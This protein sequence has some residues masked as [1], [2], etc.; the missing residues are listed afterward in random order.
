MHFIRPFG[1]LLLL[2]LTA[3]AGLPAASAL[4]PGELRVPED[5]ETIQEAIDAALADD[6]I[7]VGPGTYEEDL[8]IVKPLTLK[9]S[10]RDQT[11]LVG[12]IFISGASPV[13]ISGFTIRES[14]GTGIG[15]QNRAVATISNCA[16]LRS[17]GEGILVTHRSEAVLSGNV[18]AESSLEGISVILSSTAAISGNTI[19]ANGGDGISISDSEADIRN[20]AIRG[21]RGCGI[22]ADERASRRVSGAN[23]GFARNGGGNLCGRLPDELLETIPPPAPLNLRVS[24]DSWA[25]QP[26]FTIDWENPEDPS[27]IAAAWWKLGE[28]PSAPEDGQRTTEKPFMIA[29]PPEGEQ[30]VYVWL[31]DSLGNFSHDNR[32][33]VTVRYDKT[34]PVGSLVINQGLPETNSLLVTLTLEATDKAGEQEG[35]GVAAMRFS[36]DGRSWS[37]WEPFQ[38]RRSDWDLAA[39]GGDEGLGAKTVYAQF[40]D[41]AG[42]E[43]TSVSATITVIAAGPPPAPLN[44]RVSPDGWTN[45]NSFMI[46]WEN[47]RHPSGI[48]AAWYKIGEEPVSPEDGIR[49]TEKPFAVRAT[50]EGGQ[51]VY[52]WLEDGVGNKDHR[53]RTSVTL[54]YDGTSPTGN[55]IIDGGAA[56]TRSLRVTLT[57][58]AEDKGGSGL[59][60]MRFSNDG[61][62]WSEW[63]PFQETRRGWDLSA[64]GGSEEEGTKTVWGQLKDR[65]GNISEPFGN[66][67]SYIHPPT[68]HVPEDYST[69]QEA[70]D[71]VA[72]GARIL[73]GPGTYEENLVINKSL[74]L[75]GAGREQT[76]IKSAQEGHPVVQVESD[77]EI[78]VVLEGLEITG[79]YGLCADWP[80]RCPIGLVVMGSAQVT[81][82][83]STVSGNRWGLDV[84]GSAQVTLINSKVSGNR[85]DGLEV[86][87]SAQVTLENSTVSDNYGLYSD[88]LEVWD[89]A[90]VTLKNSTVSGNEYDGLEV[91]DSAQVTIEGSTFS[92]NGVNGLD[93]SGSA[94]VTLI[95]SKVSGNEYDGLNVLN[96]AQVT[97]EGSTFS[98]NG[99]NGLVVMGSAR[100]TIEG[101]LIEGNGTDESCRDGWICNG[102]VVMD[103]AHVEL[104]NTTIRNNTD[105]GIAAWLRKCGYD[106]DKFEGTV[107][108]EGRGNEIYGNGQ[109]DVCLP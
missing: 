32:G 60:E 47:P 42:N 12:S 57:I 38:E 50:I 87:D 56:E 66:A 45:N 88:G 64:Y 2:I 59:A 13:F 26:D 98:G 73:I 86:K 35:S 22:R 102:I 91:W 43:S 27:E 85:H 28:E 95:N 100:V 3:M 75:K 105:W 1:L 80:D 84:R 74:T 23:N 8:K 7:I 21:N 41:R 67:I 18:I 15:V 107:L 92:G 25:N 20:N 72:G 44:L 48:T 36:N 101:S 108:W 52:V 104:S 63:E 79:A 70:I 97:I 83:N 17:G 78:E 94:R 34:P 6:T 89:S 71:A 4:S 53:N 62:I 24:P 81:L 16:I 40:K 58:E 33:L 39:Y 103:E 65:A 31:E 93:V 37:E 82:I 90:Q 9:G 96:F 14:Q 46:D 61:Q 106:E 49:T 109:G 19:D 68:V 99:V 30:P 10:G 77:S 5:Y 11:I 54:H 76:V 51:P 69:I 55:L 29:E